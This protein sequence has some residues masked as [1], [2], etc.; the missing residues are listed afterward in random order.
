MDYTE[1]QD[2]YG[3]GRENRAEVGEFYFESEEE[4]D[5]I[6]NLGVMQGDIGDILKVRRH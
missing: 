5:Y 3:E 2:D 6:C 1:L 4:V